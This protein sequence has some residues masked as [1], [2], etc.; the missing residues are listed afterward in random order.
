MIFPFLKKMAF[1]LFASLIVII[2]ILMK[3]VDKLRNKRF[4]E[5]LKQFPSY[6]K[7]PLFGNYL[8][9]R[10]SPKDRMRTM[11]NIMRPHRRL[12]FWLGPFPVIVLKKYD[13]IIA[14]LN[15]SQDRDQF[16]NLGDEWLGTGI[17]NANYDEWKKSRK[18]LAPAFSSIML[19]RYVDVFN[20]KASLLADSFEATADSGEVFNIRETLVKTNLDIIIE[21][22]IGV[23]IDSLGE[24]GKQFAD[25]VPQALYNIGKRM[26]RPWLYPSFI[27]KMYLKLTGKENIIQQY[28]NLPAKIVKDALNNHKNQKDLEE[29]DISSKSI[30]SLIVKGGLQEPTFTETRMTDEL[31]QIIIGGSETSELNVGYT[32]LMLAMHQDIQQKVYEE[33]CELFK[34]NE[35]LTADHLLH[36]LKYLEQCIKETTRKY[37]HAT[38]TV[39]RT[40]K[41][42][43]LG[44]N[45]IIPANITVVPLLHLA[46]QDP[47]LYKNP[48]KWD[49]E[50]FSDDAVE[51]RPKGSFMSFG[52]GPRSCLGGR[53]A[54]MS[55]KTQIAY[56]IRKYHLSTNIKELTRDNLSIFLSIGSKIGYPIIFTRRMP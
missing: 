2:F 35:S 4:Y 11:E 50:H 15:Q 24:E 7:L 16:L 13:D 54:I 18:I 49:P 26:T 56:V 29:N 47:E 5:L 46:N 8:M 25:A 55:I 28:R 14:I 39:R 36:Q 20:K 51:N 37:S 30:I 10:V 19:S 21:N 17:I 45:T 27:H 40:H 42:C 22:T 53:Y 48:E 12:L 33:V 52:S 9:A 41:E 31:I 1:V 3:Y 44:D 32:L 38:I 34:N 23:P 43:I 6:P